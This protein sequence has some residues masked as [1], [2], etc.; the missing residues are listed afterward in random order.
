MQ[1]SHVREFFD[2]ADVPHKLFRKSVGVDTCVTE[3]AV[4]MIYLL[5]TA[6]Y[7]LHT[8]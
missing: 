3:P 5:P 7:V 1:I 4:T 6:A 8:T 2:A